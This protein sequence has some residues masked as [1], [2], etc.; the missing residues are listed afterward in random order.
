MNRELWISLEVALVAACTVIA[1]G[2]LAVHVWRTLA[3]G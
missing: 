1:L 3:A 2:Q